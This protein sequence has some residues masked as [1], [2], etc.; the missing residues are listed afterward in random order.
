M[1]AHQPASTCSASLVAGLL[2]PDGYPHPVKA[3]RLIETHISWVFLTGTWAYKVKKPVN[4]GFADFTSLES[5]RHFCEEELRLNRRLAP[6]IYES[7]VAVRGT[8][9][10]PRIEGDGKVLEYALKMREFPQHAL[11]SDMLT[12]GMLTARHVDLLA[13]GIAAFHEKAERAGRRSPFGTPDAVLKPAIDNF[14]TLRSCFDDRT[15]TESLRAL[16]EWTEREY[17]ARETMFAARQEDGFVREC[18]GDLHLRNIAVIDGSPLV[19]D[20]IEFDARLRWIDVMSE[21]AFVVMDFEDRGRRDFGWRFLNA[22]LEAT[23][24]YA[25]AAVMRFYLVYRALVRAKVHAIRARQPGVGHAERQRLGGVARNYVALATRFTAIREAAL[26]ITHGVSGSGKTRATQSLLE[27]SGAIRVRS[28]VERKR[29]YSLAPLARTGAAPGGGIYTD[30]ATV[31]TYQRLL[32]LAGKLVA[33]GYRTI[34]DAAFLKRSERES[35]RAAARTLRIP[36]FILACEA[37][38]ATLRERVAQ[39]LDREDDASEADGAVLERQLLFREPLASDE[40]RDAVRIDTS[41]P[42]S[43]ALWKTIFNA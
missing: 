29:L 23:G 37:P 30:A 26:V 39:R 33:A 13:Q 22:H 36:F 24:D 21:I 14:E 7:V 5:R 4:L 42:I 11:A 16:R 3:V 43:T 10:A 25:G 8:L 1:N 40:T 28:D 27:H 17:A 6:G 35:F 19:F 32:R 34:V 38:A 20:C 31:A 41:T 15:S 12:R 18:H 9:R 2:R